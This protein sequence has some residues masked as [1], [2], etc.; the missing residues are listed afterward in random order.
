MSS[1]G[2]VQGDNY[3]PLRHGTS[4][5]GGTRDNYPPLRHGTWGGTRPIPSPNMGYNGI[6]LTSRQYASYCNAFL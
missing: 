5:G 3:P 4:G 6:R 1:G 2:Y